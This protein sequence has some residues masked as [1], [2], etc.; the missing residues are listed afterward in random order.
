MKYTT[1]GEINEYRSESIN[2][3]LEP[4]T[5]FEVYSV[6]IYDTGHPEY[7]SGKEI[8]STKQIV[9]KDD[10]LL[11]KINPR[12]SRVWIVSDESEQRNIASTEWIVIRNHSYNPQYLAWYFR[13]EVF[14]SLMVSEVTGIGGSLTRAQP[15][16]VATY[17]VPVL[18]RHEQDGVVERLNRL[19]SVIQ[20]RMMQLQKMDELI[21]AR[22]V[23]M[24]GDVIHNTMGW[25]HFVFSDI[26]SSRL[27][28]MLD[29]KQQSGKYQFPYLANFNVQWFRFVLS[30][31]NKMDFDEDDQAEFEL[32]DGDLIVCEGGEIGRCAIWHNE[33]QSCYFQKALHRVR[34]N[35]DIVIPEYLA[36][37]FQFNCEHGGFA[38]IEGAKATIAHLP[39]AKLKALEVAVPSIDLQNEFAA[40]VSQVNKSKLSIQASLDQLETLKQSLMQK[41]FG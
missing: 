26:A 31:L 1:I 41:Y 13:S 14:K 11:C 23:E 4:D 28:K 20:Y 5:V 29:A 25:P 27:G 30:N 33:I 40:F 35:T 9:Q 39:G 37:W 15:K 38:A 18:D 7:L 36:R 21:K 16:R 8:G 10:I 2:P 32:K 12:I 34:C 3:L 17:P 24:F 19:H 22:F 6:P